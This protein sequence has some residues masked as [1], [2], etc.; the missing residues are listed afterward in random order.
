MSN[1]IETIKQDIATLQAAMQPNQKLADQLAA[2]QTAVAAL[3]E[4]QASMVGLKARLAEAEQAEAVRK[5]ATERYTID[6]IGQFG[7]ERGLARPYTVEFRER[8]FDSMTGRE[9]DRPGSMSLTGC[10]TELWA[11]IL[12]NPSK[13][14]ADIRALDADPAEAV[15]KHSRH[16]MRGYVSA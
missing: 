1:P 8:F 11:A 6:R 7:D 4:Q 5:A 12:A 3:A 16:V 13:L 9:A 15:R 2:M 14:P 10:T